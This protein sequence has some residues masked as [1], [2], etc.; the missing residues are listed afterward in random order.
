VA[1]GTEP[2]WRANGRELFYLGLDNRVMAAEVN[3]D[4][5]GFKVGAVRPLFMTRP[6]F[7]NYT[8]DVSPDGQRFLVDNVVEQPGSESIT[9]ILNWQKEVKRLV[10]TN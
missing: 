9:L 3:G 1:G 4:V 2:R 8:Y 7:S 5:S 10:P 6:G